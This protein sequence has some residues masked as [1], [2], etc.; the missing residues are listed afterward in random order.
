MGFYGPYQ[1]DSLEAPLDVEVERG[2]KVGG[3]RWKWGGRYGEVETEGERGWN[4]KVKAGHPGQRGRQAGNTHL[5][6][7]GLV[8]S[9]QEEQAGSGHWAKGAPHLRAG[10]QLQGLS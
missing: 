3:K 6:A 5:L 2:R 7:P 1:H 8:V 9:V 10:Q 4:A